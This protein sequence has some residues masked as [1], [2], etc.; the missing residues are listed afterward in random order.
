LIP[1]DD[2][3]LIIV[4]TLPMLK[5]SSEEAKQV[6]EKTYPPGYNIDLLVDDISEA[7]EREQEAEHAV[8]WSVFLH[9]TPAFRRMIL[10]GIFTAISQQLV[11]ID[12][13]QYYLL[14]KQQIMIHQTSQHVHY[15][16]C[17]Y[18]QCYRT[19]HN[20]MHGAYHILG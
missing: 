19:Y 17:I 20:N 9:P 14:G 16:L 6:L 12:A 18:V 10:L 3:Q 1:D 15:Y 4:D 5:L 11:G 8:G 2:S 13:V 7:L